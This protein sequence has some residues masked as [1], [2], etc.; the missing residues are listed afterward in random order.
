M[1]TKIQ[2]KPVVFARGGNIMCN[3]HKITVLELKTIVLSYMVAI[4]SI[5][6][7]PRLSIN[8][9]KMNQGIR[10]DLFKIPCTI[11]KLFELYNEVA[12]IEGMKIY[13]KIWYNPEISGKI[14][15]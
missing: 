2:N 8:Q 3:S 4:N 1:K 13:S 9:T 7:V 15:S 14:N 6:A 12:E 5:K 11:G 10:V